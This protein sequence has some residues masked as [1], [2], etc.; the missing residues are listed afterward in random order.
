MQKEK[1]NRYTPFFFFLL[2]CQAIQA[3]E[4]PKVKFPKAFIEPTDTEIAIWKPLSERSNLMGKESDHLTAA[5][6]FAALQRGATPAQLCALFLKDILR[7]LNG[8]S[9]PTRQQIRT[10]FFGKHRAGGFLA[11]EKLTELL[12]SPEVQVSVLNYTK[13]HAF[14]LIKGRELRTDDWELGV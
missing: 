1:I 12:R 7:E 11:V 14:Y 4:Y 9:E 13:K 10:A 8:G 2:F 6:V 3:S 5:R